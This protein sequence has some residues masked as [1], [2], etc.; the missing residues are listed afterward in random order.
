MI[1]S[2]RHSFSAP[3]WPVQ[4]RSITIGCGVVTIREIRVRDAVLWSKLRRH[5]EHYLGKWEPTAP[6]NWHDRHLPSMWRGVCR[7]QRKA[8]SQGQGIPMAIELDGVMVGQISIGN[9]VRGPLSSAW[10]GYW[11]GREYAGRKIASAALALGV[12]H[13]LEVAKLH[14]LEA[15]VQPDNLGSITVLERVGFRH[16]GLLKNYLHVDGQW[17]DHHLYALTVED[18][19]HAAADRLVLAGHTR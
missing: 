15:T 9:I 19:R 4:P 18:H 1:H 16:E 6:L 11:V 2:L 12:D 8:A 5:E 13:G 3:G 17:R 10:I 14:R 7:E